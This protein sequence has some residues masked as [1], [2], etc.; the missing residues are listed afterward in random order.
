MRESRTQHALTNIKSGLINKIIL[1]LCPFITRTVMIKILG[2]EY[3]GLNSLFTSILQ[4]LNMAE[5]GFSNAVVFSLYEPLAQND[6][7]KICKLLNFYRFVYAIIGTVVLCA[8]L[9]VTPFLTKIIKGS[10]PTDINIYIIFI[11]YLLNTSVSYLLF[12][13]KTALL[14]ASQTQADLYKISTYLVLIKTVLQIFSLSVI[15]NYYIFLSLE[16]V[17]TIA[18]NLWA[19]HVVDKR[20]PSYKCKGVLDKGDKRAIG[21]QVKGLVV[22]KISYTSRNSFDSIV[23]SMFCGLNIVA[24]YSNYYYVFSAALGI[25]LI[26]GQ[27]I[28]AGVGNLMVEGSPEQNYENFKRLNFAYNWMGTWFSICLLCLYQ[29][30]MRVWVGEKLE[31]TH[32]QMILFV[33]YFYVTQLTQLPS[34]YAAASG[35]WWELR[36]MQIGEMVSNLFLN[37]ILGWKFGVDGIIF[38]TIVTV[39]AFSFIGQTKIGFKQYFNKKANKYFLKELLWSIRFV[40]LGI[41][42][43]AL[44]NLI[45]A[46]PIVNLVSSI[47]ISCVVPNV[48]LIMLFKLDSEEDNYFQWITSTL[49]NKVIKR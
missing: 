30:F 32:L 46:G 25:I 35:I 17:Y 12:A 22:G 21:Q 24:I 26:V 3:L 8:G 9:V 37:F 5:L 49:K 16:L 23:L 15:R 33:I 43:L 42:S 34:V 19:S 20:Y 6:D 38:A 29:P 14:T 2:A 4:V 47:I 36:Y 44:C 18:N 10:Y 39:F 45:K 27:S 41:A 28:T 11:I 40:A 31:T 48:L 7:D 1:L 13:Y